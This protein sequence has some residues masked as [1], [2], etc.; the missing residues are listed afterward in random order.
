L[1][2]PPARRWRRSAAR[3][4]GDSAARIQSGRSGSRAPASSSAGA[5]TRSRRGERTLVDELAETNERVYRGWLL[6][7]PRAVYQAADG[8][9][10]TLLLDEWLRAARASMLVPFIRVAATLAEHRE[11]IV[12]AIVLGLSNARL[13]AMNS[14]V[15]LISHRSRGFRRLDSLLTMIRLVCGKVPDALPT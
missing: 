13:E 6:D 3:I 11:G 2:A 14:T 4:G 9:H 5:R 8:D 12:K 15:R 10:A 7:Q 1:S